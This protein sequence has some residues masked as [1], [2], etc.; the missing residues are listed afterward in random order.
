MATS[1]RSRLACAAV[2]F[3]CSSP[4]RAGALTIDLPTAVARAREHAPRAVAARGRIAK[5]RAAGD[6]AR[7]RFTDN[8]EVELGAGPRLGDP[9]T[10]QLEAQIGQALQL[11]RRGPRIRV[12]DAGVRHAQAATA[13]ELR[14]LTFEVTNA[15]IE[16]RYA[17]LVVELASHARDVAARAAD[18]SERRRR[19]GD[20]TDLDVDLAK[21]ALGRARS[22]VAA[23]Q[24]ERAAAL[25]RV[26]ALVGAAPDDSLTL[27]GDLVPSPLTL[28][29]LRRAVQG[30]ADLRTLDAEAEVA[31]AEGAL[32]RAAGRPDL[33]VWVGYERDDNDTIVLGGLSVTLP[34]WNRAQGDKAVARISERRAELERAAVL[35]S[36]S[37]HVIDAFEAYLRARESVDVFERDVVPSLADAEKLLDR[38]IETGQIAMSDFLVARQELLTGRREQLDRQLALARAAA[39][40]RFLAGVTP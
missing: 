6:G 16:A 15:F 13:A 25:G 11:G 14:E 34:I 26:A 5:A 23:A 22:A 8:P 33:G 21:I 3:A 38:S 31:R 19:A 35:A 12:A 40:A 29:A 1:V 18:A 39:T 2:L 9:R 32:A 17:D 20:I 24:A 36:A 27:V 30:R 28:D 7:V 4:A 37:R 10:L